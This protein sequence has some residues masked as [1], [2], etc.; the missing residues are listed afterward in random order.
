MTSLPMTHPPGVD[1]V[2]VNWNS[3]D[4]LADCL[5][6]IETVMAGSTL[7][8]RVIVVDNASSDGSHL[9]Y[10]G[11]FPVELISNAQNEGF[12]RACNQG[13]FRGAGSYVPVSYTHLTLPTKRIV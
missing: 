6:S 2:I 3:G 11:S 4:L 5:K 13:A 10:A 1:I 9:R 8:V 12:A 7:P